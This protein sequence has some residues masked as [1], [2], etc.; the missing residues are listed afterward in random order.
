[1]LV[2]EI[3]TK[4]VVTISPDTG[5]LE[6]KRILDSK[7]FRRLPVVEK[8]KLVGLVTTKT[9]ERVTPTGRLDSIWEL[10]YS[11]GSM[12]RTPVKS[13]MHTDVVTVTPGMTVEEALALAQSK[14]V[15]ALVVVE[16]SD[17]VVGIVTSNDFFYRIVNP[18]LGVGK[19]GERLW[20]G[21]GGE[22]KALED[23][24][25]TINK[26]CLEIITLHI[27]AAPKATKKDLVIHINCKDANEIVAQLKAKGYDVA[28]RKR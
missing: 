23:I 25:S 4:D 24:I 5:I 16:D 14:K 22:S 27:I 20:I 7:N 11:L 8:G 3:M 15:G 18:I 1:M 19:P 9:L 2:R 21:G 13:I 12:Y 28:T 6:A 26:L 17:K 10:S